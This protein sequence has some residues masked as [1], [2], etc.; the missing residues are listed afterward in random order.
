MPQRKNDR[1]TNARGEAATCCCGSVS[2]DK[3]SFILLANTLAPL[4][5][6]WQQR[7]KFCHLRSRSGLTDLSTGAVR[8][9]VTPIQPQVPDVLSLRP[10]GEKYCPTRTVN[11]L[12]RRPMASS[13]VIRKVLR[14]RDCGTLGDLPNR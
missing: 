2:I 7:K 1:T 4:V 3:L 11:H 12:E 6:T 9:E 13:Q 5:A 14:P 10:K 8:K